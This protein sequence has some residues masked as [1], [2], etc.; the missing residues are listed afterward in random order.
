MNQL[1][2]LKMQH[3]VNKLVIMIK[4]KIAVSM[5]E[6][7]SHYSE[8]VHLDVHSRKKKTFLI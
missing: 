5:K 4:V 1:R 3:K 7:E 8:L 6:I 2:G